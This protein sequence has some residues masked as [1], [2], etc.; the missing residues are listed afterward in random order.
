MLGD[1]LVK[2]IGFTYLPDSLKEFNG[3]K[4]EKTVRIEN[5]R[6]N[7]NNPAKRCVTH[8]SLKCCKVSDAIRETC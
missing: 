8:E 3:R 2:E 1:I 7:E 5:L 4:E 6:R